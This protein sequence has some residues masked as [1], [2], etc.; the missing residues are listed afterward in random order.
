MP[1]VKVK[2]SALFRTGLSPLAPTMLSLRY[3]KPSLTVIQILCP[4]NEALSTVKLVA[5]PP[6]QWKLERDDNLAQS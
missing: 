3:Q 4:P 5:W 6:A 2:Y 1:M